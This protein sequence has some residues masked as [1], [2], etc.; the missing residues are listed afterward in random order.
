MGATASA[1]SLP[2]DPCALLK[3]AEIQAAAPDARI[4]TGKAT[5]E[6]LGV[7][8][9]YEWGPRTSQWGLSSVTILATDTSQVWPG[10][11]LDGVKQRV[12]GLARFVTTKRILLEVAFHGDAA[13]PLAKKDS[14]TRLLK[15]AGSRL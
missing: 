5:N 8:C 11:N 15:L 1:G 10:M 4:G 6:G 3:P 12:D 7:S 2:A 13:A 14:L 9:T